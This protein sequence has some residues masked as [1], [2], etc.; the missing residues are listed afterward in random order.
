MWTDPAAIPYQLILKVNY[1]FLLS[2]NAITVAELARVWTIAESLPTS[3]TTGTLII[4]NCLTG[5]PTHDGPLLL[6]ARNNTRHRPFVR[7]L[8]AS[9][10]ARLRRANRSSKKTRSM[11]HTRPIGRDV[12]S[13]ASN[14]YLSHYLA[15]CDHA[16]TTSPNV[17]TD[18]VSTD[19]MPVCDTSPL[20][21][22]SVASWEGK[23]R[24][25]R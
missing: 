25:N 18:T 9:L 22:N 4:R 20:P 5:E 2:H 19:H 15:A 12:S 16:F 7:R 6:M 10:Y 21:K 11:G 14:T 13:Q 3:A 23:G 17:G 1:E 8:F 24:E